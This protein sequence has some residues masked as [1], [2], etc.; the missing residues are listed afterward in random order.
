MI[1]ENMV[2]DR[3]F[4]VSIGVSDGDLDFD[5]SP[6]LRGHFKVNFK[7]INFREKSF[8]QEFYDF[9]RGIR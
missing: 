4:M 5:L 1:R 8:I 7:N 2:S 3:N 9:D 6:D